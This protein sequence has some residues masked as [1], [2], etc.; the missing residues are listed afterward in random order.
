MDKPSYVE[1]VSAP[2]W[3][4]DSPQEISG[5]VVGYD[6]YTHDDYGTTPVV[7]IR[8]PETGDLRRIYA[9]HGMLLDR[10]N[11]IKPQIGDKL[12]VAYTGVKTSRNRTDAKGNPV[13][14]H[15]YVAYVG[16]G[17]TSKYEQS[18]F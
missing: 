18:P 4:P 11:E 14:Y 17:D 10:L 6:T 15:S 8:N 16:D 13:E 9:I 12:T 5:I 1:L 3:M 7:I 2:A